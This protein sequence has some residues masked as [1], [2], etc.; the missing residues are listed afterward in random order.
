MV[1]T[2]FTSWIRL[3]Y[4]CDPWTQVNKSSECRGVTSFPGK[5][6]S[7]TW[8]ISLQNAVPT[9]LLKTFQPRSCSLSHA[10]ASFEAL[11]TNGNCIV[12]FMSSYI[13]LFYNSARIFNS[14]Q[15]KSCKARLVLS[16]TLCY[17]ANTFSNVAVQ[18]R[19]LVELLG[20]CLCF[21]ARYMYLPE[22]VF[23]AVEYNWKYTPTSW[24]LSD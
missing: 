6:Q 3:K 12:I 2:W 16:S 4:D 19:T 23:S 18:N 14:I 17:K 24:L 13:R 7:I 15:I 5:K 8:W 9:L 20:V 21:R 1:V 22:P 11:Q 10:T